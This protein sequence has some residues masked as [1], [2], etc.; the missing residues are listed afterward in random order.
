MSW[1]Q[2]TTP[3]LDPIIHQEGRA[4][5]DWLGWCLAYVQTAF[6]TG[7]AGSTA[8]DCWENHT[9]N[10]HTDRNLPSGVYVPIFF[11]GYHGQG[12]T[13]IYKD[14]TVWSSPISHKPTADVWGSI[15]EVER[16]YGV[17][18]AGWAE[19]LGGVQ[20]A[21]FQPD[22]P[23]EPIFQVVENY[24]EGKQVKL[25]KQPTNLWGMNYEFDYMSQHP[26][27]EHPAGEIW[28]IT[29]KVLHKDGMYYYR[30]EG[31]VDGFN[32][33][34]CDDYT[35]PPIP[36]PYVPP[37]APVPINVATTSLKLWQKVP[38]YHSATDA[39]KHTNSNVTI[40]SGDYLVYKTAMNGMLNIGI[41]YDSMKYWIDPA[42]ASKSPPP[43]PP[44]VAVPEP[45]KPDK[46]AVPA[47]T[48]TSWKQTLTPLHISGKSVRYRILSDMYIPDQGGTGGIELHESTDNPDTWLP[49]KYWITRNNMRYLV[50]FLASDTKQ[51]HYYGIPV[52][53]IDSGYPNLESELYTQDSISERQYRHDQ[54]RMTFDDQVYFVNQ[55]VA[56]MVKSGVRFLDGIIKLKGKKK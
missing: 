21:H 27:E 6:G 14:G 29:N 55:R 46:P 53:D 9:V 20:V 12:H 4:L 34:D 22:A 35:P 50:P 49:I 43:P 44:V 56:A 25:N 17:V 52:S 47:S 24:P 23:A 41:S 37:A 39:E 36:A 32:V 7:W 33:A 18:Y 3:N 28:S 1:N 48:D 26:V 8:W 19:G 13:A 42:T 15:A 45:P 40:D 31:Q 2:T 16:H 54:G 38:A 30:R 10:K 11:S 51:T 5:S